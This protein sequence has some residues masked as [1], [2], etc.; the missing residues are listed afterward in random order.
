MKPPL[1][2]LDLNLLLLLA[3]LL[4]T[5]SPTAVAR[6]LGKTQSAVSHGLATLR[7]ALGDPL[8]VRVG[9]SL[10]PTPH[11]LG[12]AE[13]L[14]AWRRSTARLVARSEPLDPA[15]LRRT[16]RLSM[17]DAAERL[18][19]PPLLER[20][21]HVA[22]GVT[23]DV[24]YRGDE[25]E[26]LLVRGGLDLLLGFQ[27]RDSDGLASA[28]LFRDSF[29]VASRSRRAPSLQAFATAPHV[30]VAPR[31]TPGGVVDAALSR[32]GSRRLVV[33]RTPSF[34]TAMALVAGPVLLTLPS[35]FARALAPA[36]GVYLH[37][38]PLALPPLDFRMVFA[39]AGR[40]DP[41][42]RWLRELVRE[43]VP[44]RVDLVR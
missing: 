21:R 4:E 18:L 17:T 9:R 24:T 28:T 2:S 20:L 15:R 11:A 22:P 14:E 19:L 37:P 30:L 16:F 42:L 8:F 40:E 39:I 34:A 32:L 31:A 41:P 36:R 25:S 1:A 10:V 29:V 23:L 43:C 27:V 5:P 6:R 12:L 33:A 26:Q 7:A 35:R 3:E 13:P 38:P 44:R